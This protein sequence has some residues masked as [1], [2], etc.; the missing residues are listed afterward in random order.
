MNAAPFPSLSDKELSS[1]SAHNAAGIETLLNSSSINPAA[2]W[3]LW[4]RRD[5]LHQERSQRWPR[6]PLPLG[7]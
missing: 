4:G 3:R 1:E 7:P 2:C 6:V 5:P